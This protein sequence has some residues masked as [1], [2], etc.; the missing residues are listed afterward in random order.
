[1]ADFLARQH[2]GQPF[3]SFGPHRIE[4]RQLHAEDVLEEKKQ[5]TQGLSLGACGDAPFALNAA[6]NR[7]RF[8][9]ICTPSAAY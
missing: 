1:V 4:R 7:R 8:L 2:D 5:S 3:G 6:V 9:A